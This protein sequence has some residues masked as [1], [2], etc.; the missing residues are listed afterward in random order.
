MQEQ[1]LPHRSRA[2]AVA[3][4]VFVLLAITA[5][6]GTAPQLQAT[7]LKFFKGSGFPDDIYM[8]E[9]SAR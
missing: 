8:F 3:A 1:Q 5:L 2:R 4:T 9:F 7:A 6:V